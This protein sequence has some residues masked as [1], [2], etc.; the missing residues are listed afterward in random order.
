MKQNIIIAMLTFI[1]FVLLRREQRQPQIVVSAPQPE[2]KTLRKDRTLEELSPTYA[3]DVETKRTIYDI[4]ASEV[5]NHLRS[6]IGEFIQSE[7]T[8]LEQH[9]IKEKLVGFFHAGR[10]YDSIRA[11][12]LEEQADNWLTE[13]EEESH[14]E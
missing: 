11:S 8:P 12:K 10:T 5:Y 6:I 13:I 7:L 1:I 4:P 2:A 9:L 3:K 14:N